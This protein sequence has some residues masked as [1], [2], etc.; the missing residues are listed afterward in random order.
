VEGQGLHELGLDQC[1]VVGEDEAG[2]RNP[3]AQFGRERDRS[4]VGVGEVRG[5][6]V[7]DVERVGRL[8]GDIKAEPCESA[9]RA[10]ELIG[11]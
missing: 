7:G 10:Y 11:S 9:M 1:L 3:L 6:A 2:A 5:L 4:G 8:P